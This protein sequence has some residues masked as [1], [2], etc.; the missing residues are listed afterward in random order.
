[1]GRGTGD[2]DAKAT[3][4]YVLGMDARSEDGGGKGEAKWDGVYEGHGG[5]LQVLGEA[6]IAKDRT[7]LLLSSLCR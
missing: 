5:C 1:M 7:V 4:E 3:G 6:D 2:G